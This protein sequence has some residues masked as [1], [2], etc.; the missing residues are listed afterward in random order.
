MILCICVVSV[1]MSPLSFLIL[2]RRVGEVLSIFLFFGKKPSYFCWFF[3]KK[4]SSGFYF[5]YFCSDILFFLWLTLDFFS[6]SDLWC[7]VRLFTILIFLIYTFTA[8]N[9][10]NIF[11]ASCKFWDI[12]FPLLFWDSFL[13]SFDFFLT[14]GLFNSIVFNFHIFVDFSGFLL[15]LISIFILLWSEKILGMISVLTLL[16]LV[17]WPFIS[18]PGAFSVCTRE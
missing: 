7:E 18:Y 13:F 6:F 4:L 3:L 2:N 17:L 16:W 11:A 5:I 15:L 8:I 12:L 9:V 14:H 1:V 10:Q